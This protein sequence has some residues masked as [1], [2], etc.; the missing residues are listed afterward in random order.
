[1]V[2][3]IS[4]TEAA[5]TEEPPPT[6][7][8]ELDSQKSLEALVEEQVEEIQAVQ[9]EQDYVD[10]PSPVQGEYH[11]PVAPE[12]KD[13]PNVKEELK[14]LVYDVN[15]KPVVVDIFEKYGKTQ[16]WDDKWWK[17]QNLF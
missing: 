13:A 7:E 8:P 1:M 12:V 11:P 5:N 15:D 2:E 3:F 4:E 17:S 10:E 9:S 6:E 14:P 16:P